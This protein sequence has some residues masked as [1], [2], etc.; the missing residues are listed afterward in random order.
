MQ[1]VTLSEPVQIPEPFRQIVIDFLRQYMDDLTWEL[2]NHFG[3]ELD[4]NEIPHNDE[5]L[6]RLLVADAISEMARVAAGDT[7]GLDPAIV[8]EGIQGLVER[9]F[10]IPGQAS[11]TIPQEFWQSDFGSMV[12]A[13]FMWSQGDELITVTQAAEISGKSVASISNMAKRGRLR[14]YPDMRE[15][16]PQRRMRVLRSE[17]EAL[18]K[19]Q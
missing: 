15:S 2:R 1:R 11:Y 9:M 14:Q 10:G 3:I 7:D 6:L 8:Y 16:N 19:P 12:M 18:T 17:I 4:I 13:A 5:D